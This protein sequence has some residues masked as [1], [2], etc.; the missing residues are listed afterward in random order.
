M[1]KI[2]L[3]G[4]LTRDPELRTASTGNQVCKFGLAVQRRRNRQEGQP[5]VDF[6]NCT[7][8]GK[9]AENAQKYLA[10]GRKVNIIGTLQ[11]NTFD[12]QDGAKRT[13]A[14]VLVDDLEFLPNA[15]PSGQYGDGSYG[16]SN[17]SGNSGGSGYYGGAAPRQAEPPRPAQ[18]PAY[19][20]FAEVEEDELPF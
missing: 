1:N 14:D 20:G 6:F 16:G 19:S 10:K 18:K 5:D 8:F 7:A 12:G 4:N 11:I 3:I 2:F 15:P 13:S 17:A 9:I